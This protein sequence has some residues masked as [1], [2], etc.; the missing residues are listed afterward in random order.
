MYLRGARNGDTDA[1]R[2]SDFAS[3]GTTVMIGLFLLHCG[4]PMRTEYRAVEE[5]REQYWGRGDDARKPHW[6]RG[7]E[8]R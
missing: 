1:R 2:C 8:A 3:Y 5:A 4:T 7:D 6:G